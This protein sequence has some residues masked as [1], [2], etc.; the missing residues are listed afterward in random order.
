MNNEIFIMINN[1]LT[2]IEER[3]KIIETFKIFIME[4]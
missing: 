4:M 3:E 2:Y 1:L